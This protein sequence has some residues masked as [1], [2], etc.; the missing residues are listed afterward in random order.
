MRE[1]LSAQAAGGY[2]TYDPATGCFTLPPEHAF[3]LLDADVPGA[4]Q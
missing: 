2:V 1:W 3:L 4:F